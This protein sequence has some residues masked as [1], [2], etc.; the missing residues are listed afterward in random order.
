MLH[1][2]RTYTLEWSNLRDE[3]EDEFLRSIEYGAYPAYVLSGNHAD[4]LKKSYSLWHYSL[5]YKDWID[6]L[7]E[8]Y[9]KANAA[10]AAVQDQFITAHRTLAP[11]VKET[12]FGSSYRIVVNYN[13]T[14]YNKDGVF[15][16]AKDF[17]VIK[18]GT[19][20]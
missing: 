5:N 6:D 10:L 20:P 2:L 13:E 15:V 14:D 12:V 7:T 3:Y 8:E 16:P 11:Q 4:D 18:G 9:T 19:T 1:G 17:V